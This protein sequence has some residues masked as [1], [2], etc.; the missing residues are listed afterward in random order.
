MDKAVRLRRMGAGDAEA[1]AAIEAAVFPR[2]WSVDAFRKE[3]RE[4]PVA[5]YLVAERDGRIIG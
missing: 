2:P 1:V 4:N 5:R 3:M